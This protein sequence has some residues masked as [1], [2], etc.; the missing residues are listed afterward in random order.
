M[1]SSMFFCQC[2]WK[3][4]PLIMFEK[5]YIKNIYKLLVLC[6]EKLKG[7]LG[8]IVFI[9]LF[10]IRTSLDFKSLWIFLYNICTYEKELNV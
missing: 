5:K 9:F 10:S 3:Q 8:Y 2:C 1:S 7:T 6:K 4:C